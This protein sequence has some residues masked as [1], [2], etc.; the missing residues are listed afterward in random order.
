MFGYLLRAFLGPGLYRMYGGAENRILSQTAGVEYLPNT[1]ERYGSIIVTV[2]SLQY[3]LCKCHKKAT[4]FFFQINSMFSLGYYTSPFL[5]SYAYRR[6][7]FNPG[8]LI[9]I[10]EIFAG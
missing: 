8:G 9:T 3:E 6:D 5:V 2:V 10:L 4:P 7:M 1:A